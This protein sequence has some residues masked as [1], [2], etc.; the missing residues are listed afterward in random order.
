MLC[1]GHYLYYQI[2]ILFY[3]FLIIAI[4][5][6]VETIKTWVDVG[7]DAFTVSTDV[8]TRLCS[9]VPLL[10]TLRKLSQCFRAPDCIINYCQAARYD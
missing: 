5:K 8:R 10:L 7:H 4:G 3:F 9:H 1:D 6:K 2:L